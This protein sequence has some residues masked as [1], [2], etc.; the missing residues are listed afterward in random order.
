M[1]FWDESVGLNIYLCNITHRSGTTCKLK[2]NNTKINSKKDGMEP[3]TQLFLFFFSVKRN[4]AALTTQGTNYYANVPILVNKLKN[5]VC[6]YE[7]T[8]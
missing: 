7:T 1:D 8:D 6:Y 5:P 2:R 4:T 3:F